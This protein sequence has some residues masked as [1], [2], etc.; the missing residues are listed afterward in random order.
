[1]PAARA[2]P[3]RASRSRRTRGRTSAGGGGGGEDG[4]GGE[5]RLG[6]PLVRAAAGVH[7]DGAAAERGA[8]GGHGRV[9]EVAADVVDDLG[10]GFNGEAGGFGVVGV[11]GDR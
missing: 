5:R 4:G 1:M 6:A 7:Q 3:A 9:P 11:D 8:G 10:A 2:A